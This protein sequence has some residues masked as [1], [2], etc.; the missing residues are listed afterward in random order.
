M[1]LPHEGRKVSAIN[2]EAHLKTP[3]LPGSGALR[4]ALRGNLVSFPARIPIL[5]K[6]PPADMQWRLVL[7]FYVRGWSWADIAVR[8]NVPKHQIKERLNEWSARALARGH[9][10]IIDPQGFAA[11][12]QVDVEYGTGEP[13]SHAAIERCG[14]WRREEGVTHAVV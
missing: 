13:A 10:Q 4:R 12:C 11:S 3:V 5:L 7:L 1:L 9:I 8:F 14:A 2:S 6:E